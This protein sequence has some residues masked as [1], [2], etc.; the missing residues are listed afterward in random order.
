M[1][2]VTFSVAAAVVLLGGVTAWGL[3]NE[4]SYEIDA[5][6]NTDANVITGEE[7]LTLTNRTDGPLDQLVF[8]LYPNAFK[9]GADTFYQRELRE[10]AGIED[11]DEI[12]ADPS[13]DAFMTIE[14]VSVGAQTLSYQVDDTLMTVDLAEPLPADATIE[15]DIRFTYNMMEIPSDGQY[16]GNLALRTGHREGVYTVT[17]WYPKLAVYDEDGWNRQRYGYIGEFYGD[18]ADYT[19]SLDVPSELT[20]GAT[21]QRQGQVMANDEQSRKTLT[22]AASRVHDVAWVASERFEVT[23]LTASDGTDI[24]ALTLGNESDLA[25]E[26]RDALTYFADAFG[27]YAYETLVAADVTAGGGMEYPGIIMIGFGSIR[28]IAHEV[29]HQ[30]WYGA[31]GN[32]EYDEAWLDEAFTVYSDER[33]RMEERGTS[34]SSTRSSYRFR[35]PGTPVL[36]PASQFPTLDRYFQSAYTKGSGILWMLEGW[37]G[38]ETFDEILRTYYERHRFQNVATADFVTTVE[39]VTDRDMDDFFDHW[40]RSTESLDVSVEGVRSLDASSDHHRYEITVGRQGRSIAPVTVEAV[41]EA[42]QSTTFRWNGSGDRTTFEANL[43]A[44]LAE[45][46]VDPEGKLLETDR[47]D[48]TWDAER[49]RADVPIWAGVL[50]LTLVLPLARWGWIRWRR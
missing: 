2:I 14:N 17:L 10:K 35:E 15:L 12:Y 32:D 28:E 8:H 50:T 42:D 45:V 37:L 22:Y 31:V 38:R 21:G 13:D 7:T 4:L 27:P 49:Q 16:A 6:L 41:D 40:L 3:P 24:Q 43:D 11:L 44:P 46:T 26:T 33:Y 5:R 25:Q 19:V 48:N 9:R 36:T 34:E 29:G 47:A 20:V 18:Y 23:E 39:R 1:R 30:W